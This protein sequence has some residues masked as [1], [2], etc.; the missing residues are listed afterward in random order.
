MTS[1]PSFINKSALYALPAAR[2][3]EACA[4]DVLAAAVENGLQ[5]MAGLQRTTLG[6]A[7]QLNTEALEFSN[8]WFMPTAPILFPFDWFGLACKRYVDMQVSL[9]RLFTKQTE[10]IATFSYRFQESFRR[11]SVGADTADPDS[12][13]HAMDI[14]IGKEVVTGAE[15]NVNRKGEGKD[16][17]SRAA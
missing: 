11:S 10:V 8:R 1:S 13:D 15:E 5:L 12:I 6:T 7:L 17:M 3:S 9:F 16:S 14:V 2:A 4:T